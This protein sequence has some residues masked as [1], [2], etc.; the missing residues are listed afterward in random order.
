M[1]QR[2]RHFRLVSV[3]PAL[4]IVA[5]GLALVPLDSASAAYTFKKLYSFCRRTNCTD[6][7]ELTSRVTKDQNG[8][9]YGTTKTGGKYGF[10]VVFKLVPNSDGS[11]YSEYV[12]HSF[13]SRH[14]N[15]YCSDGNG[16]LAD[17]ILDVDGNV[18][19]TTYEGGDQ[20]GGV[21]FKLAH[22][23]RGWTIS[24]LK[25]FCE[26]SN[27]ADGKFLNAGLSYSGQDSGK[28]WDESSP[29]F[30]VT[31]RGGD[32]DKGVAYELTPNGSNWNFGRIHNFQSSSSPNEV[33]VDSSGNIYG[34]TSAGGKYGGGLMYKLANGTWSETTLHN[35][36]NTQN[37]ADGEYPVI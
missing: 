7:Q 3:L 34:T 10:G 19:G 6:G 15:N 4:A 2:Y 17:V 21:V 13:C 36:C 14:V 25:Q 37:C 24:L 22:G 1:R 16:P 8:N 12:L 26:E 32:Y 29:L 18:Y 31:D 9:L 5:I 33:L 35:F 28:A 30:G 11:R 23:S 27:C 20:N